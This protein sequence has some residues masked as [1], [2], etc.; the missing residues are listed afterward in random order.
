MKNILFVTFSIILSVSTSQA[1]TNK[2]CPFN[3]LSIIAKA[4]LETPKLG[5]CEFKNVKIDIDQ[6][7]PCSGSIN[8]EVSNEGGPSS[9]VKLDTI[10]FNDYSMP[11]GVDPTYHFGLKTIDQSKFTITELEYTQFSDKTRSIEVRDFSLDSNY[12]NDVNVVC[13]DFF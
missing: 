9:T 1:Q 10:L 2:D 3:N 13:G 11:A 6:T 8:F 5:S 4:M 12:K 7:N